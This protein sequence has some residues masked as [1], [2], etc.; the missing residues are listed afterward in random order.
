M[1]TRFYLTSSETPEITPGSWGSGW[2]YVNGTS[3]TYRT[4]T[5]RLNSAFTTLTHSNDSTGTATFGARARWVSGPLRAQ[6]IS[7]TLKGQ[8]ICA[9]NNGGNNAT[10]AIAVRVINS[11]GTIT[12]TILAVSASDNTATTPPEMATS[13]TNRQFQNS[14]EGVSITL[15]STDVSNGDRIVIEVGVREVRNTGSETLRVGDASASD[16]AE[17]NTATTDANPWVEFS[18]NISFIRDTSI[19]GKARIQTQQSTSITGKAFI[20]VAS[21][22]SSVTIT[23]KAR[24]EAPQ[25]ISITG[26]ARIQVSGDTVITGKSRIQVQNSTTIAGK[27]SIV[28]AASTSTIAVSKYKQKWTKFPPVSTPI[29]RNHS[30]NKGL[31]LKTF[32][33]EGAGQ[34]TF[35]L[36]AKKKGTLVGTTSWYRTTKGFAAGFLNTADGTRQIKF[37]DVPRVNNLAQISLSVWFNP[38]TLPA[39]GQIVS[40]I[41]DANLT[42][43]WVFVHFNDGSLIWYRNRSSV[44]TYYRTAA[45]VITTNQW[46]H[47][48]LT[49]SGIDTPPIIYLNGK[50]ISWVLNTEIGSGSL[51]P[52]GFVTVGGRTA[53][54]NDFDG[55]INNVAIWNRPLTAKEVSS[56]YID[57]FIGLVQP[58]VINVISTSAAAEETT[59][60]TIAKVKTSW[61]KFPPVSQSKI[62]FNNPLTKG[63]LGAWV[64]NE[65]GG[66]RVN[67]YARK[68]SATNLDVSLITREDWGYF[69][70]KNFQGGFV[71]LD[72]GN[73]NDWIDCGP[74]A[75][76]RG[77]KQLTLIF[78]AYRASSG[79]QIRCGAANQTFQNTWGIAAYTDGR[80]YA[81]LCTTANNSQAGY[82]TASPI[83]WHCYA[84]VFDGTQADNAGRLKQYLDGVQQTLT[85]PGTIGAT[86]IDIADNFGIGKQGQ[87]LSLGR[88]GATFL[89]NRALST[90]EIKAIYNN[91]YQLFAPTES[92]IPIATTVTET[93]T[94]SYTSIT[95]KARIQNTNSTSIT[96][97]ARL[98]RTET[99][100]IQGQA[101]VQRTE[102]LTQQG[103]ARIT[104]TVSISQTGLARIQKDATLN[105]SGLARITRSASFNIQGLARIQKDSALT[106]TGKARVTNSASLTQTGKARIQTTSSV[107]ILGKARVTNTTSLTQAGKARIT[108]TASISQTGRARIT[109]SASFYQTGRARIQVASSLNQQGVARITRTEST[110]ITG[111]ARVQNSGVINQTGKAY[112]GAA[113]FSTNRLYISGLARITATNTLAQTGVARIQKAGSVNISGVANIVCSYIE[114][115]C[116]SFECP[117]ANNSIFI[118]GKARIT[119]SATISQQGKARVQVAGSITQTGK[120]RVT[121]TAALSITGQA[122]ITAIASITQTGKARVTNSTN[123]FITGKA[124]ITAAGFSQ[125]RIYISG[126]AR[127]T[128]TNSASQTGVARIQRAG[129]A[130]ISGLARIARIESLDIQGK[131]RVTNSAT[132]VQTGRARIQNSGSVSQTGK[133][134]ISA[135]GFNTGRVYISGKANI[136]NTSSVTQTGVARIQKSGV[137][138]ISGLARISTSTILNQS[139]VARV[140]R[141]EGVTITGKGSIRQT[142]SITQTGKAYIILQNSAL[143]SGRARIT[144]SSI[145]TITGRARIHNPSERVY[146]VTLYSTPGARRGSTVTSTSAYTFVV[147]LSTKTSVTI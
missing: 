102:S 5:N 67:D 82:Y 87:N 4:Y 27:A 46:Y 28:A 22:T 126:L 108:Q 65:K 9:E 136:Q 59:T 77:A 131:A 147:D 47:V 93:D 64:M 92:Y 35:D 13:L 41:Q 109:N 139:G 78:W 16:L 48:V 145:L 14:A 119:N 85:F 97:Q 107:S 138:N 137:L 133:A 90:K 117:S 141:T 18:G 129:S 99:T 42:N 61:T 15:T 88:H 40:K 21:V 144:N 44:A 106:Q 105:I 38:R 30:I 52:E 8:I 45:G 71:E 56:L 53:D 25:S 24:I 57:P 54:N 94:T 36:V 116:V 68:H 89:F 37:E 79:F 7:G 74:M 60:T 51:N 118:S 29:D 135:A 32:I 132:V 69:K 113:G 110:S 20:E 19:T 31:V 63:I 73:A 49:Q 91:P 75:E 124:N 140:Q 26:K 96:G 122:R 70:E 39:E 98:S 101:R 10:I 34:T 76:T 50:P 72:N 86:V 62:D 104:Q 143:I 80:V 3:N 58:E 11:A 120:A 17:N 83:G 127:I 125:N 134:N 95:G 112:I 128:A 43:G 84:M 121:Q 146:A 111:K 100:S 114:C 142:A 2:T 115:S 23:G 81:D 6:T 12:Q 103:V 33:N 130:N 55:Y 1:A 66:T 123:T